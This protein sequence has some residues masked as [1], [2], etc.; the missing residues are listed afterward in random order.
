MS[1]ENN[2]SVAEFIQAHLE[3]CHYNVGEIALLLGFR[4]AE[5]VEGFV[6]GERKVPL[7]KVLPLAQALG[8]DKR[9]LFV[10]VLNS[11]FDAEFVKTLEEVFVGDSASSTEQGWI[12]FLRETYGEN[13]PQL[14]PTL[15]RRLR[16]LVSLPT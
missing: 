10:L 13:I 6:R 7:D 3:T 15:R 4:G 11:W 9:R 8:C 5:M 2:L 14:T 16:L 1:F 12:G